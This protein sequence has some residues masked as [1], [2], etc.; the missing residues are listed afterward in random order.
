[1]TDRAL[2]GFLQDPEAVIIAVVTAVEP[3][4]TPAQVHSAITQAARTRAQRRRLAHALHQH[5]DLLISGRPEG[6]PQIER[7]IRALQATGAHRLALPRCGHCHRPKPLTQLDGEIRI[8]G[9][10]DQRKRSAAESCAACGV[11]RHI[12][13]RDRDGRPVCVH[14]VSYQSHDPIEEISTTIV[15]LDPGQ[16][17]QLLAEIIR[18]A[19]PRQFQRHKVL[20]ELQERPELLTG[21][22]A[23]GSAR[24]N[25][26]IQALVSA[27]I[28]GVVAP[29]CPS[30]GRV[31]PLVS[32]HRDG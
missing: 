30:C 25:A 26:L 8:C 11:S 3:D 31:V 32:H 1:M 23:Y 7:L 28:G 18:T 20:W 4:L 13:S 12:A 9:S 2:T 27:G 24:V 6:P 14:C 10:C 29:A 5:P 15:Q 21:Q 17:P 22:G 16:K 19:I